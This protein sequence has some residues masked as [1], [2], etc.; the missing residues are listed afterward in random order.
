MVDECHHYSL[1]ALIMQVL[2]AELFAGGLPLRSIA[3]TRFVI[4][5]IICYDLILNLNACFH[6]IS[7]K[8]ARALHDSIVVQHGNAA[9]VS[10]WHN[11]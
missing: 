3:N 4:S 9:A 6:F 7:S 5:T 10:I 2:K 11:G 8:A 1:P